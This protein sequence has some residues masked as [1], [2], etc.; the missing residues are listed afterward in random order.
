MTLRQTLLKFIYPIWMFGNKLIGRK[1][2][3]FENRAKLPPQKSFYDLHLQLNDGTELNLDSFRG[4][5]VLLVNTASDCGYTNQYHD[6]QKLFDEEKQK[7]VII[8]FPANDFK[9]QEQGN[10]SEIAAFCK[11]NFSVS[12]PLAAKSRVKKGPNQNPVFSWLTDK[13]KNGWT[14]KQPSWNFSKWLVNEEGI[15]THYFD[16]SVSP[17]SEEVRQAVKKN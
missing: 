11:K 15:L 2:K 5:K 10:D 17:L 6:L 12:F 7:L 9:N 4:K 13:A 3:F 8:G 14:N 16:P 1:S